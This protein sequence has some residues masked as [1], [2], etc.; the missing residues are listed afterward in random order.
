MWMA[1]HTQEEI[2]KE[3]GCPVG[4]VKDLLSERSDLVGKVLENQTNQAAASHLTDYEQPVYNVS[5]GDGL[6]GTL[7]PDGPFSPR[8]REHT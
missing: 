5:D 3:A 4:T 2:A 7:L 1:C 8:D 6:H